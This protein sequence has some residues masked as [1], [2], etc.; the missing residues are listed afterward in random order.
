MRWMHSVSGDIR[1]VWSYPLASFWHVQNFEQTPPD[2]DVQ[3]MNVTGALVCGLSGSRAVCPVVMHS[4]SC[5]YPVCIRWCPFDLSCEWDNY[6][7][8]DRFPQSSNERFVRFLYG[9]YSLC[10]L[11]ICYTYVIVDRSLSITCSVRMPSLR[12][13]HQPSQPQRQLPSPDKHFLH[14]LSV[15]RPLPS[16]VNMWQH[17]NYRYDEGGTRRPLCVGNTCCLDL[18][19]PRSKH[20]IISQI[21]TVWNYFSMIVMY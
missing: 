11:Y 2:K 13:P 3:W 18:A 17:H 12:L 21:I 7:T 9:T 4:A 15:R 20:Q 6:R 1:F 14:F 8:G 16:S 10:P 5:K 19:Q